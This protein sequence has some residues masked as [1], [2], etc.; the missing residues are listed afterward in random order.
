MIQPSKRRYQT[1]TTNLAVHHKLARQHNWN[2]RLLNAAIASCSVSIV[3]WLLAI[4]LTW[5]LGISLA[6]FC[7][8]LLL[9][10]RP[11]EAWAL[12][13]INNQ[14][15]LSYQTAVELQNETD[16]YGFAEAVTHKALK[17]IRQFE[18]PRPQIWWLP[19]T[20]LALSLALLPY[21]PLSSGMRPTGLP[22]TTTTGGPQQPESTAPIAPEEPESITEPFEAEEPASETEAPQPESDT[23]DSNQE[24]D[25]SA[26]RDADNLAENLADEETLERFLENLRERSPEEEQMPPD[27]I[28]RP[29]SEEAETS[30]ENRDQRAASTEPQAEPGTEDGPAEASDQPGEE[31]APEGAEASST[32]GSDDQAGDEA[33]DDRSDEAS[34]GDQNESG[35]MA[36]D[37]EGTPDELAGLENDP[38]DGAG[39]GP[40]LSLGQADEEVESPQNDPELLRGQLGTGPSSTA[41]TIRLPGNDD[42]GVA[43]SPEARA[44]YERAVEQAITEGRIPVEYQEI[45]RNYFR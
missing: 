43:S 22:G 26:N 21:T 28:T 40:S 38:A 33:Q 11:A 17:D 8:A 9:P 20:A 24:L 34:P 39:D 44:Q 30:D 3:L 6:V 12:Q 27:T 32:D 25:G 15:G 19:I 16:K 18:Q 41:G 29:S 31:S 36:A 42:S 2:R 14:V 45:I 1:A 5:H 35:S 23:P 13:E 37:G 10:V 7:T 4:P